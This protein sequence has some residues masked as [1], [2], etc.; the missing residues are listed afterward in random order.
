MLHTNCVRYIFTY[1]M[2]L[3][4]ECSRTGAECICLAH[5]WIHKLC[6]LQQ[7]MGQGLPISQA[8]SGY[9]APHLTT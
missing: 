2:Q 3:V 9:N 7:T 1:D 5:S 6:I 4:L 8:L